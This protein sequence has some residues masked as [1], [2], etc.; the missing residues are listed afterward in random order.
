MAFLKD[1]DFDDLP[2]DDGDAFAKL[3]GISRQRLLS[4]ERDQ[5]DNLPF[6]NLAGYMN[7]ITA[8]A[9][10]LNIP[11]IG[12][13][14]HEENNIHWEYAEFTRAVE[15]RLVQIRTQRARRDRRNSVAISGPGRERIQHHIERLKAEIDAANIPEKRKR[16]LMEKIA[17]FEAELAKKRFNLAQAMMLVALVAASANDLGGAF[18]SVTKIVHSISE[19]IGTE[20]LEDEERQ[21]LLPPRE[22]FKAI[23]DMRQKERQQVAAFD[24]DDDEVPF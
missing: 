22:P 13:S 12:F 6:E 7:E 18:D 2:D 23:P 8:L 1:E 21:R 17:D 11:N 20:K 9:E 14:L 16:A 15:Y 19:T 4:Q 10:Q 24:T 5:N 3:E